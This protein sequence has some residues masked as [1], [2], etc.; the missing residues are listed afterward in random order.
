MEEQKIK[1][2]ILEESTLDKNQ[3]NNGLSR[4]KTITTFQESIQ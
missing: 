4:I 2:G 3:Y 1:T